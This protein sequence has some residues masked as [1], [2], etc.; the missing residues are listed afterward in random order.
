MMVAVEQA[1]VCIG[2]D[3]QDEDMRQM[4][5][6]AVWDSCMHGRNFKFMYYDLPM[7]KATFYDRRA[8]FLRNIAQNLNFF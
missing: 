1:K 5:M 2:I 6:A 8:Q 4:L 3:L 7:D